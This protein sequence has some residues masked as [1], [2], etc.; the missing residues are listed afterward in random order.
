MVFSSPLITNTHHTPK[1]NVP[2]YNKGQL[3]LNQQEPATEQQDENKAPPLLLSSH[4]KA[5]LIRLAQSM[6]CVSQP[7]RRSGEG[8]K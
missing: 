3:A 1:K 7:K 8:P 5:L 2:G 4:A 6:L